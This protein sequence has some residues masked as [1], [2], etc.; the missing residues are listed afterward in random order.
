MVDRATYSHRSLAIKC[1]KSNIVK[2]ILRKFSRTIFKNFQL[3]RKMICYFVDQRI[4]W[5][6][7]GSNMRLLY[8]QN[9]K[10]S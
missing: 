9:K 3:Q 5:P 1:K 8:G 6:K 7:F 10:A 4:S 2:E